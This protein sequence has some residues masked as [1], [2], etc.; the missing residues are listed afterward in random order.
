MSHEPP[1]FRIANENRS[2]LATMQKLNGIVTLHDGLDKTELLLSCLCRT[3][4]AAKCHHSHVLRFQVA[5][6]CAELVGG[7]VRTYANVR[8]RPLVQAIG[9][10]EPDLM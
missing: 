4:P 8:I 1:I 10:R 9:H 2:W 5:D 6:G 7:H 3:E